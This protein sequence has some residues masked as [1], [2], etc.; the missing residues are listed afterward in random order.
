MSI[1]RLAWPPAQDQRRLRPFRPQFRR[2]LKDSAQDQSGRWGQKLERAVLVG[3]E[4]SGSATSRNRAVARRG[5]LYPPSDRDDLD[6]VEADSS[7]SNSS[8]T[9][10]GRAESAAPGLDADESLAEFRELVA[11]AGGEVA[12]EIMQRRGKPDPATLVGSGKVDEIAGVAAST[13]AD[14]VLFDHDLTPTQLRNLEKALPCRV[15]DRTQL[16][17]DIFARHARTSES[18]EFAKLRQRSSLHARDAHGST[19]QRN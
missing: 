2:L 15:L 7:S 18:E 10:A 16:I 6:S 17:L 1:G 13:N 14:L 4:V 9:S 11:S 19:W 8:G 5:E 12:A 3:L